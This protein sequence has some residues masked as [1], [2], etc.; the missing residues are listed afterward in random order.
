MIGSGQ[1]YVP[2][3]D[4]TPLGGITVAKMIGDDIRIS[5]DGIV[6]G[7]IN[8]LKDMPNYEGEEKKGHFF[9]VKFTKENY[10]KLHVGG[11]VSDTEFTA[12]KDFTPSDNDPYLVIRVEN[13][14]DDS[15]VTIYD[16]TTKQGLFTLDFKQANLKADPEAVTLRRS[17]KAVKTVSD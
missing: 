17:R 9:P 5:K 11:T 7:T 12:G 2:S 10:K 16:A 8:Y 14:T 1:A 3:R 13:C 4:Q 15:K 6:T